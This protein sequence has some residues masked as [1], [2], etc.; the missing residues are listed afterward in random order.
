M[1]DVKGGIVIDQ[2]KRYAKRLSD[3][4]GS[5]AMVQLD[6]WCHK[7][8]DDESYHVY[9]K[10]FECRDTVDIRPRFETEDIRNL[11]EAIDDYINGKTKGKEKAK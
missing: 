1:N 11:G 3:A 2:L 4:T 5:S 8:R 10:A 7:Y 6:V 9:L